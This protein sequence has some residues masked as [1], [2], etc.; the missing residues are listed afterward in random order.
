MKNFL[1]IVLALALGACSGSQR[2]QYQRSLAKWQ[3]AGI[4]HYSFSLSILCFC[5]FSENMPLAIE[6]RDHAV[7]SMHF[8][9]GRAV[10]E[11]DPGWEH[12]A[13]Y[14]T[15]DR[16]FSELKL[17]LDGRSDEVVADYDPVYGYPT[18][19]ALDVIKNAIDDELTLEVSNFEILL[20]EGT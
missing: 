12:F 7:V 11:S 17:E 5:P 8:P 20:P 13:R 10:P 3:D 9:D 1:L 14:A 4:E 2:T 16:V 6:V 19:I 15:I 18:R